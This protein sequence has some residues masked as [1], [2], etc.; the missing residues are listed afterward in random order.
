[1]WAVLVVVD[2]PLADDLASV[3][4][5]VEPVRVETLVAQPSVEALNE[6]VVDGL[7]WSTE[8]ER[9]AVGVRPLV[10]RVGDELGAVVDGDGLRVAVG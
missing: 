1:M 7:A 5:S 9:D 2:E 8:V 6:R 3:L 10:E 4:E